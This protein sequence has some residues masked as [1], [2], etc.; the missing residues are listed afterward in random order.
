M[1]TFTPKLGILAIVVI[2]G[3]GA[4]VVVSN[5]NQGGMVQNRN[6][7]SPSDTP[8][9]AA[10]AENYVVNT[11][12]D[13]NAPKPE[14]PPKINVYIYPGAKVIATSGVRLELQSDED[15]Q[16]I[17]DWYKKKILEL[18]FNAK[19]FAQSSAN[20]AIFNKLSAAK[21]GEKLEVSIK[22]DQ[23]TSK[24]QITVDRS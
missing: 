7:S 22:K 18:N 23:S 4:L 24:V 1:K 6:A 12:P 20:G 3:I 19:S 17:T 14:T 8:T 21:P 11:S 5:R 10:N 13:P 2:L 16:K 9:L 15:T